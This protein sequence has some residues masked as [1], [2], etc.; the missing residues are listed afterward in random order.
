MSSRK[1]SPLMRL[2]TLAAAGFVL[3][4]C[5]ATP[6]P[7]PPNL[8]APAFPVLHFFQGGSEGRGILRIAF[9]GPAAVL[10]RSHGSVG[11]DGT[12]TLRQEVRQGEKPVRRREWRIWEV[13]PGRYA[14]TL[15]DASGPVTGHVQGNRLHL[16]FRMKNGL[17][18]D[19]WLTLAPDGRAARN[20]M[21]V[22]K[23]GFTVAALDETI[24][25]LD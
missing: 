19:Q 11:P 10:V 24:R 8:A 5:V 6:R 21:R 16:A 15:S 22:R 13:S 17:R 20:L 14:G 3:S 9:Q 12:L 18:A 25:K 23:F 4:A 7:Q 2:L 1:R